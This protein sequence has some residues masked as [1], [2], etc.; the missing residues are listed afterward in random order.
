M[1]RVDGKIAVVTGAGSCQL[2]TRACTETIGQASSSCQV[3]AASPTLPP[4]LCAPCASGGD[5]INCTSGVAPVCTARVPGAI[6]GPAC[7]D[8]LQ[9]APLPPCPSGTC[10]WT[11]VGGPQQAGWR[12]GLVNI[13]NNTPSGM[14][15]G[16]AAT[17]RVLAVGDAAGASRPRA[18]RPGEDAGQD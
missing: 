1:N 17:I 4:G 2:G 7:T 6:P 12:V 14:V 18:V 10:T 8:P 13:N 11:I 9:E 15:S 5:P 3:E 16:A